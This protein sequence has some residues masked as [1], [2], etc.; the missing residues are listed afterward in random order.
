MIMMARSWHTPFWSSSA[1]S[2]AGDL[3][4]LGLYQRYMDLLVRRF[5]VGGIVMEDR[6]VARSSSFFVGNVNSLGNSISQSAQHPRVQ[7]HTHPAPG[8]TD[9][10]STASASDSRRS[11]AA[12]AAWYVEM[13]DMV[14]QVIAVAEH[15]AP[16]QAH[17]AASSGSAGSESL[18]GCIRDLHHA[19][20]DACC[21]GGLRRVE[22][23]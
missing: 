7:V 4:R 17:R 12:H 10:H 6:S 20:G 13:M 1:T 18:R 5:A 14:R 3:G 16:P 11:P 2:M 15:P 21:C 23:R 19:L 9:L 22:S 8:R